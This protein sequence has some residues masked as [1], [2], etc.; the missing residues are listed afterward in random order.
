MPTASLG[1]L[2]HFDLRV[3]GRSVP[4]PGT[5]KARAIL[6]Y[7]V[8]RAG[9][10]VA[11]E[12]LLDIF[13]PGSGPVQASQSLKTALSSI[14]RCLRDAGLDPDEILVAEKSIV[15]WMPRSTL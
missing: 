11:R 7:L 2:G 8:G 5:K 6:A 9:T 1:T 14:R 12:R 4:S 13:W 15:R 3:E 10:D